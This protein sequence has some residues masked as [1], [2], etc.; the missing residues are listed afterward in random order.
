MSGHT[1]ER[2]Q[3]V[4]G[5]IAGIFRFFEDPKNLE[6]ITP[7][8]MHFEVRSSTDERVRRGTEIA[9][10][11]RWQI[12]PMTWRSRISEYEEGELFADEMLQGPYKR[13]CHHHL[14]TEVDGGVEVRDIV[15]YELPFG[16]LG[17][18]VH[19]MAVRAQLEAIFQYRHDAIARIF[20]SP[21]CARTPS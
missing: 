17:R 3:I 1:L 12:F 13:W 4:P 10:R 18:L 5:D 7:P 11:L 15:E 19:T 21:Q 14:F 9:Y 8:W 6:T 16:P 2:K 20:D